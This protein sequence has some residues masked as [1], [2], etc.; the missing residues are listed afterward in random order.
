MTTKG[1][2]KTFNGPYGHTYF[3][4]GGDL[5]AVPTNADG[6]FDNDEGARLYVA[7]FVEPLTEGEMETVRRALQ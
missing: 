2:L 4:L 7:D 1:K 3:M 5:V 6:S